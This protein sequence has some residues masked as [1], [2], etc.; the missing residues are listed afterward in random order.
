MELVVLGDRDAQL[1]DR[2]SE[3]SRGSGNVERQALKELADTRDQEAGPGEAAGVVVAVGA[4]KVRG[5]DV[6]GIESHE[7]YEGKF[8]VTRLAV[9]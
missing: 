6:G 5:G 8:G 1:V 4:G 9:L 2:D 7:C 3:R